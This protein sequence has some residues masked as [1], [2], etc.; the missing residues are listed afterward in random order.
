MLLKIHP[1]N[2]ELRKITMAVESLKK[3]GVIIYPTDTVYGLGC[4][5]YNSNAVE[6]ICKIK[7]MNPKKANLSILCSDFSHLSDFTSPIETSIFRVMK[8]A[9]PGPFTFIL[10]ANSNVPKIFKHKKNTVGIRIPESNIAREIV[11]ELGSPIV[12]T[13]IHDTDEIIAYTTDP[14]IIYDRYKNI[15]DIVIDGGFGNNMPST[16]VDCSEGDFEVV[17]QGLGDLEQ[18]L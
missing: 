6:R 5:I 3:G 7:G 14:E 8:K 15:V 13:T 17:R 11:K 12:T 18:Y 16:I 9:L 2:P 4:D 1:D 10:K